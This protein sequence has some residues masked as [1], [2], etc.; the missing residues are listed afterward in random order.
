[1]PQE[2]EVIN[3]VFDRPFLYIIKDK[4]SDNIWFF[5]TVYNPESEV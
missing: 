2:K 5:G 1:M 3:I 4:N